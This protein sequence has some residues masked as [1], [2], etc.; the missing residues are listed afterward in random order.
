MSGDLRSVSGDLQSVSGSPRPVSGGLRSVS[1][2]V[3]VVGRS[4]TQPAGDHLRDPV[5][6]EAE[7]VRR[8]PQPPVVARQLGALHSRR[9]APE[10]SLSSRARTGEHSR[11]IVRGDRERPAEHRTR[12]AV[13]AL[14][15]TLPE[16]FVRQC[17]RL[18][19][20]LNLATNMSGTNYMRNSHNAPAS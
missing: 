13:L 4:V 14:R 1:G 12:R 18:P 10:R 20:L 2:L 11:V 17:H 3:T 5:G 8:Q 16:L 7:R 6:A 15:E 19:D 9:P